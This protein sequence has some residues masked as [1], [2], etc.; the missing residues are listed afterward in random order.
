MAAMLLVYIQQQTGSTKV[1]YLLR[2]HHIVP[3]IISIPKLGVI[4]VDPTS[5]VRKSAV[6]LPI[7][8][9]YKV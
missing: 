8:G 1:A 2:I 9:N 3:Y 6:F 5:Q 4:S 7:L